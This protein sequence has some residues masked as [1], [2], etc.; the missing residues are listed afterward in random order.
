MA[1]FHEWETLVIDQARPTREQ[2]LAQL[3]QWLPGVYRGRDEEKGGVLR[4]FLSLFAD[5]L[6]RIRGV[7]E[8]SYGDHFIDSAQDWVIPYLAELVGTEILFTGAAARRGE[9]AKLNREDVK[10]TIRWRRQKGTLAGLQ[11]L[12]AEVGGW[13]TH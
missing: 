9:I 10:N 8:A 4:A 2:T 6:W 1:V 7:I 3:M 13:G 12:S 11:D 5:E